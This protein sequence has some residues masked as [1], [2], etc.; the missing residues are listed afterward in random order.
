MLPAFLTSPQARA[1][2]ALLLEAFDVAHHE[3]AKVWDF[4]VEIANLRDVGASATLLR[5]LL[6]QGFSKHALELTL[7]GDRKRRFRTLK[8]PKFLKRSCFVL[9]DSGASFVRPICQPELVA[10]SPVISVGETGVAPGR[11]NATKPHWNADQ[12]ELLLGELFVTNFRGR[13]GNQEKVVVRFDELGWPHC[14]DD[15]LPSLPIEKAQSRLHDVVRGLNHRQALI[16]YFRD[17][18]GKRICW[19]LAQPD[20]PTDT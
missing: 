17:G 6:R 5:W 8:S 10:N 4:A 16:H 7:T 12:R 3:R 2:L 20:A 19:K 1:G 11:M 14:M 15:P 18:S 9:T 13:R